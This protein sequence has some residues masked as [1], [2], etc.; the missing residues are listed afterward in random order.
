MRAPLLL[1]SVL[2]CADVADVESTARTQAIFGGRSES[3]FEGIGA[4]TLELP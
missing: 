1:L 4:L 2:G 3:G